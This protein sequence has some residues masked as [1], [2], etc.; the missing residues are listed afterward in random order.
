MYNVSSFIFIQINPYSQTSELQDMQLVHF[1]SYFRYQL[2]AVALSVMTDIEC[3][4]VFFSVN[5][6]PQCE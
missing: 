1:E 4:N 5:I 3:Y 6:C 2:T